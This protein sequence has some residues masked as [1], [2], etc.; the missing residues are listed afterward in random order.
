VT[1]HDEDGGIRDGIEHYFVA[2]AG[3]DD[4]LGFVCGLIV[5]YRS[6]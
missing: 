2:G 4:E 5:V 3:E 6:A 1:V